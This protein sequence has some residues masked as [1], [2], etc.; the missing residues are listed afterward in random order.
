MK[1]TAG[2]YGQGRDKQKLRLDCTD[3]A[4]LTP[5]EKDH[6]PRLPGPQPSQLS[7][8][9]SLTG[10]TQKFLARGSPDPLEGQGRGTTF[11]GWAGTGT[12]TCTHKHTHTHTGHTPL[13]Q[14][15]CE[16]QHTL[17]HMQSYTHSYPHTITHSH[18]LSHTHKH[19]HSPAITPTCTHKLEHTC[20]LTCRHRHTHHHGGT[21]QPGGPIPPGSPSCQTQDLER[22]ARPAKWSFGVTQSLLLGSMHHPGA[23]PGPLAP[24][25]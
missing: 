17:T 5:K 1:R 10:G 6:G 14:L 7:L 24:T 25:V 9:K 23:R 19:I 8:R 13:P 12:H 22:Q 21:A 16:L 3:L 18:I 20:T 4:L 2:C 11:R 15:T